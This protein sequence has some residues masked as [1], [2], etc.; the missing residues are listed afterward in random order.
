VPY[1]PPARPSI[2]LVRSAPYRGGTR[3]WG[4]RYF[5]TGANFT[6]AQFETLKDNLRALC[7]NVTLTDSSIVRC[8]GYNIGSDVP[9]Y[10][11]DSSVAGTYPIGSNPIMPLEVCALARLSTSVRSVKNHPIYGFKYWHHV[12]NDGG[13]D[14]E[15]CRAGYKTTLESELDAMLAGLSD[16]DT[17]RQWCDA[18]GAVFQGRLVE[19]YLTHRDF[20]NL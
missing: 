8:I 15:L 11:D 6:T 17:T 19:T 3:E 16:G 4:Q 20:P 13:A 9:V 5:W 18:K 12:Q 7:R 10:E 14:V 1:V 2:R